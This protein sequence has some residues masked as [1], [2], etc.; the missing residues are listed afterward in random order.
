[1][2]LVT[3]F[4]SPIKKHDLWKIENGSTF[5]SYKVIHLKYA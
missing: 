3:Y 4:K 5:Y 1:M 2:M